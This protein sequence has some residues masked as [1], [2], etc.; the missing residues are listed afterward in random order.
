MGEM[1]LACK[2]RRIS[3]SADA[4]LKLKWF[5]HSRPQESSIK[6]YDGMQKRR[7]HGVLVVWLIVLQRFR[8]CYV[9]E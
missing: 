7:C 9:R 3:F 8:S 1:C 6:G 5:L 4:L 2:N